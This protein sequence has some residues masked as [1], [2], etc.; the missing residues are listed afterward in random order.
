[1]NIQIFGKTK[2]QDTKKAER[3]FKERGIKFQSIDLIKY[4]MSRGEYQSVKSAVGG[5]ENL[6]DKQSKEYANKHIE[7]L[8]DDDDRENALLENP[9]MLNTPI[10]RNGKHATVGYAPDVWKSW[11]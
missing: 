6:V 8:S 4:G 11:E 3:Y 2:C 9:A 1:M 5:F 10:V 7:Y